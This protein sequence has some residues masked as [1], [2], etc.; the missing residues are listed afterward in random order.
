M[1]LLE[2]AVDDDLYGY[3]SFWALCQLQKV[4]IP[5]P[6]KDHSLIFDVKSELTAN[7]SR[8]MGCNKGELCISCNSWA[9]LHIVALVEHAST[10]L[11]IN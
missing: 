5:I 7:C 1:A 8:T 4:P 11:C 2:G 6:A 3:K 10:D 9:V